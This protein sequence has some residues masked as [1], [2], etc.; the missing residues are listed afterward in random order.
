MSIGPIVGEEGMLRN[1]TQNK[2]GAAGYSDAA[3]SSGDRRAGR[4]AREMVA[5]KDYGG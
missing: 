5:H 4:F 2:E 1:A 3:V